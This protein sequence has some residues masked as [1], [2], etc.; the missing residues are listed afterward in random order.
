MDVRIGAIYGKRTASRVV[1]YNVLKVTKKAITLQNVDNPLSLFETTADKLAQS[2]Y[3]LISETPFIDTACTGKKR[4]AVRRPNRC[5]FT[6]DFL[7]GRA[8]CEKPQFPAS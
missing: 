6:L 7:E 8:D 3:E 1:M 4:K 5:P 2:G